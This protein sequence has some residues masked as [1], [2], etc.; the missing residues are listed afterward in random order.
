MGFG[1]LC[2]EV[3]VVR[4]RS[5]KWSLGQ[6][7]VALAAAY[8]IA[9]SSLL[10]SFTAAQAAVGIAGGL[11][12]VICHT[13]FTDEAPVPTGDQTN[14]NH[15]ANNCCVG[16]LMLMARW[17]PPPAGAAAV[18]PTPSSAIAPLATWYLPST[19]VHRSAR[20]RGPPP[21]V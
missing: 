17:P 13:L 5:A 10:A 21:V 16:C 4:K 8:A 9:L 19:T 3:G 12:G 18:A 14:G 15:C 11:T 2:G 7:V 20:P 1:I 6:R